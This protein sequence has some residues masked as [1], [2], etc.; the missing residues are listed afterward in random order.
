MGLSLDVPI[1]LNTIGSQDTYE[2]D[3]IN[4]RAIVWTLDFTMKSV[5][6]GPVKKGNIIKVA[7][8]NF[9]VAQTE[10]IDDA[11]NNTPISERVSIRPGLLVNGSPTSNASLSVDISLI[12][13]TDDYGFIVDFD[14]FEDIAQ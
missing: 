13:A 8:T 2:G 1:I 10:N 6:F 12:D 14:G 5:F 4:R 7:N 11:I 9:Y 3:F